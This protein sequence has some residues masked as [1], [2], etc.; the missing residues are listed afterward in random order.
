MEVD[1]LTS[2]LNATIESAE[3]SGQPEA[4]KVIRL[5]RLELLAQKEAPSI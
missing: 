4:A 1:T 5:L 3:N 2:W